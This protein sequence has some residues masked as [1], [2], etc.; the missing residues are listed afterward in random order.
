M[1]QVVFQ[2]VSMPQIFN[3]FFKL[4]D[5]NQHLEP[6]RLAR[7]LVSQIFQEQ[8]QALLRP[9]LAEYYDRRWSSLPFSAQ[10]HNTL[11]QSSEI[12]RSGMVEAVRVVLDFREEDIASGGLFTL[13][14]ALSTLLSDFDSGEPVPDNLVQEV[15]YR[16]GDLLSKLILL[17]QFTNGLLSPSDLPSTPILLS[18]TTTHHLDLAA[19]LLQLTSKSIS[20]QAPLDN[21]AAL[22]T[23]S[24]VGIFLVAEQLCSNYFAHTSA[25][26]LRQATIDLLQMMS[27]TPS[28]STPEIVLNN[29][30][31]YPLLF[32]TDMADVTSQVF[33]LLSLLLPNGDVEDARSATWVRALVATLPGVHQFSSLLDAPQ[34]LALMQKLDELDVRG[35]GLVE[36]LLAALVKDLPRA[37]QCTS[38]MG[39]EEQHKLK[40]AVATSLLSRDF[41]FLLRF[42]EGEYFRKYLSTVFADSDIARVLSQCLIEMNKRGISCTPAFHFA[43]CLASSPETVHPRLAFSLALT[44]VRAARMVPPPLS[45]SLALRLAVDLLERG[46][47]QEDAEVQRILLELGSYLAESVED[48]RAKAQWDNP[49]EAAEAIVMLLQRLC[50]SQEAS[51]L[52][53]LSA[54]SFDSLALLLTSALPM[55]DLH[56]LDIIRER[57][58]DTSEAQRSPKPSIPVAGNYHI[59]TVGTIQQLVDPSIPITP[60]TPPRRHLTIRTD[61]LDIGTLS[62]TTVLRSPTVTTGLTKTYNNNDFR[63]IRTSPTTNSSRPPSRHVDVSIIGMA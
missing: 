48:E 7:R 15:W 49:E 17:L 24:T 38:L 22:I 59:T 63:Q 19:T 45:T 52:P 14:V 42:A 20:I 58:N 12:I 55:S 41:V 16:E 39:R 61:G 34:R 36:W 46:G 18:L 3:S 10:T 1:Y 6:C 5:L 50:A 31:S 44:L 26:A 37:A 28:F 57:T 27:A 25:L 4:M 60:S 33:R 53:C 51:P 35:F 29:I 23:K 9:S 2:T 11:S 30:L 32:R 47:T 13:S 43:A 40:A 56:L 62:P 54:V 21:Q 8:P